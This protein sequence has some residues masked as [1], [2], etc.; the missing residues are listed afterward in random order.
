[1]AD[2]I[3]QDPQLAHTAMMIVEKRDRLLGE[4]AALREQREALLARIRKVDRDLADCRAAARFFGLKIEF[5]EDPNEVMEREMHMRRVR[6]REMIA[7][8]E[9]TQRNLFQETH[10]LTAPPLVTGPPSLSSPTLTVAPSLHPPPPLSPMPSKLPPPARQ[11]VRECAL[12]RLKA[13]GEKGAKAAEIREYFERTF[14]EV[15]HEKT[16]GMTLYRLLQAKQVHR[17]GHTWFFGPPSA[18]TK[19]PGGETPGLIETGK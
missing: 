6:E 14:G 2:D 7:A 11:T 10:S 8:H 13:A 18:E 5:P 15:V 17:E 16:V 3:P 1:M 12:A 4:R 9:A 19:N